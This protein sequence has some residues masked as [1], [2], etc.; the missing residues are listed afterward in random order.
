MFGLEERATSD[1]T[2]LIV[3]QGEVLTYQALVRSISE[4]G[5]LFEYPE[6]AL[7]AIFGDRNVDSVIAYLASLS[8][9]H[10]CGFFGDVSAVT[11]SA[12]VRNYEPESVVRPHR[13]SETCPLCAGDY[14]AVGALPGGSVVHSRQR[15]S[16][17]RICADLA[18]LLTT[19]GSTGSPKVIRLS[20]ANLEANAAAIVAAQHVRAR[21]RA[22]TSLPLSHG[23]GLA[24]LN[25]SLAAAASVVVTADRVLSARFWQSVARDD[26][27]TF[28]GV[29]AVYEVLARRGFN[30]AEYPA[31]T[32]MMQSGG[33]LAD[34]LIW[35]YAELMEQ[36]GGQFWVMYGQ[37]EACA[38]ITCLPPADCK[39][40]LGSVGRVIPG[41]T[42]TIENGE[43]SPLPERCTGSIVY[44]GPSVM[45]GYA[46]SRDDL[47]S[48][49]VMGGRLLT[50]DVG[51][52]QDGYLYLTGRTKRIV[53]VLG[54]R[55]ELD[56]VEKEFA[57]L[58]PAAVIRGAGENIV[59][60]VETRRAEHEN[61]C[62]QIVRRLGL[63]PGILALVQVGAIPR[64]R[65]GKPDYSALAR[66][67][68]SG[69]PGW[70]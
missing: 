51:Y 24:V 8:R 55:I 48:G 27:T 44:S 16:H 18:L 42:L 58:G 53:K 68:R 11:E 2:A 46:Q 60:F 64:T 45:L 23:Y 43:A 14:R 34:G 40:R 12:L 30:P 13:S 33:R 57:E 54:Y 9:G 28:A 29:P 39:K 41:G 32:T 1:A 35:R 36:K 10:A 15:A 59:V 17:G 4:S 26:V 22:I 62:E 37:T 31:L 70:E 63:P 7:V 5:S 50:G 49:D 21:D 47:A 20:Q 67:P 25:S 6:K 56:Q 19:S 69:K 3:G 52:L 38:R 65:V 66:V 61:M